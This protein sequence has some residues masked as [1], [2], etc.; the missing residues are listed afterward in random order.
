[1][2]FIGNHH[3]LH[4]AGHTFINNTT[5]TKYVIQEMIRLHKPEEE[6]NEVTKIISDAVHKVE[7]ELRDELRAKHYHHDLHIPGPAPATPPAE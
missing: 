1:M 4:F 7:Q 2:R 5:L 6:Q 3:A